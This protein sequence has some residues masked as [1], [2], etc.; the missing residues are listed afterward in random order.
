MTTDERI[1]E[2]I[3]DYTDMPVS[4]ILSTKIADTDIDS[5][6][7]VEMLCDIE[8]EFDINIDDTEWEELGKTATVQQVIDFVK[9]K[10][11][12]WSDAKHST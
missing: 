7:S 4:S 11:G 10:T 3:G 9:K 6:D 1:K 12:D 2:I 8:D 5:L